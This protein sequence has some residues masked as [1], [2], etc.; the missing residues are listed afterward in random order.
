MRG[1]TFDTFSLSKP[2]L[3]LFVHTHF[4][5]P[6]SP[7]SLPLSL[8]HFF[9]PSAQV[10]AS[11][12]RR[13]DAL[14]ARLRPPAAPPSYLLALAGREEGGGAAAAAAA[15]STR[16]A[17]ANDGGSGGNDGSG[18][19]GSDDDE[20][21]NEARRA[22]L[23]GPGASSS[24]SSPPPSFRPPVPPAMRPAG[25]PP[26]SLRGL[27][28]RTAEEVSTQRALQETLAADLAGLARRLRT[29]A[30]AAGAAVAERERLLRAAEGALDG[31]VDGAKRSVAE[32]KAVYFV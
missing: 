7:L 29:N 16:A 24:S 14:S 8:V 28:P 11:Y 5:L 32:V 2:S 20:T 3:F 25:P 22:E 17:A 9:S 23:L 27:A 15:A 18:G 12:K 26:A 19:G 6:L 31:A 10:L 13:A 1:K 21:R 4:S 30:E